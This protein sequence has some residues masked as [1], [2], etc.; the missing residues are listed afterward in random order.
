MGMIAAL[1]M[2]DRP[3]T[4]AANDRFWAAI[5]ARLGH[6][7]VA[8][9]RIDDPWPIWQSPDLLL[10]QT[11]GY[12]YR[13]RLHGRVQL[14]GTPDYGLPDCAPAHYNSAFIVHADNPA[15]GLADLAGRRFAYNEP[16]SQ[17]GWAAPAAHMAAAGLAFG[18]LVQTG[19]HRASAR[20]VAEGRADFAALDALTWALISEHDGFA[21]ALRVIARTAPTPGLPLITSASGDPEALFAAVDDAIGDLAATDRAT[22][23]LH[24]LTRISPDAYLAV[25]TPPAPG[26]A[27][28]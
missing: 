28:P 23:H 15:R 26:Q 7:P 3:E 18:P 8:L 22:L 10:A 13:A 1:P 12:P 27:Q 14:V 2:Y 19:A 4:A 6:G 25:P 17:S 21:P 16:M 20:A 11:C 5:R 9:T 24:G